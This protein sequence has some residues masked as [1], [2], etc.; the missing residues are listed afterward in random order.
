[1]DAAFLRIVKRWILVWIAACAG[2]TRKKMFVFVCMVAAVLEQYVLG[3][4]P[5]GEGASVCV[6]PP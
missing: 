4:S 5:K 3:L 2:M 6:L 1:M